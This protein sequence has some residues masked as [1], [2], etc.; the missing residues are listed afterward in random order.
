MPMERACLLGMPA[1]CRQRQ[2][3]LL[4]VCHS[5]KLSGAVQEKAS[6]LL[7]Q[8]RSPGCAASTL[9]GPMLDAGCAAS[10]LQGPML[11]AE[12]GFFASHTARS[13]AAG[14]AA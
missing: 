4:A 14:H 10:T 8:G 3:T 7:A 1:S 11:D 9:Q 12:G 5:H 2:V 13:S 6:P